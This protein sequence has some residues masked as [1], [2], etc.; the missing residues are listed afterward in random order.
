MMI[1]M[2]IIKSFFNDDVVL[3]KTEQN[4][5]AMPWSWTVGD[6]L[7]ESVHAVQPPL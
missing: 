3:S 4:T 5:N 1:N 6:L 2:I 7:L